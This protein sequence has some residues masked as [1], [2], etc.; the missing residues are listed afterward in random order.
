MK[1]LVTLV[2]ATVS[3][4]ASAQPAVHDDQLRQLIAKLKHC[5]QTYAPA[6]QAA[7]IEKTGEIVDFF[8]K[9]CSPSLDLPASATTRPGALSLRDFDIIGGMPPGVLR[10]AVSDEWAT[11]THQH[12]H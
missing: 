1:T 11:F 6:A 12:A 7:G 5:V 2:L 9:T 8:I 4:S 10:R 3:C